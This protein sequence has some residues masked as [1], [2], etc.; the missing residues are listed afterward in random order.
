MSI[1]RTISETFSVKK[2]RDLE[3]GVGGCSS[4]LPQ[5]NVQ[6]YWKWRYSIDH[7][8]ID[9]IY[10]MIDHIY[11][12]ATVR[13]V[14]CCIIFKLFDVESSWPWKGHS[15]WYHS[16]ASYLPSKV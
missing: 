12:S 9:H 13:I 10:D 6:G 15:N 4:P 8:T 11:W 3:T 2:Q 14:V 16:K 7:M 1:C 5:F